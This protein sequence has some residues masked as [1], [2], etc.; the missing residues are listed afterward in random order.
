ME[1]VVSSIVEVSM[2]KIALGIPIGVDDLTA[3]RATIAS[4]QRGSARLTAF[5]SIVVYECITGNCNRVQWRQF[6]VINQYEV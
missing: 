2:N 5:L 4:N 1:I 3:K 6:W